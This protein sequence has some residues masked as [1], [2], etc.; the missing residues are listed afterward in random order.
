LCNFAIIFTDEIDTNR[1]FLDRDE[2]AS[3][4]NDGAIR[5]T[6][7]RRGGMMMQNARPT[8]SR[9]DTENVQLTLS[10]LALAAGLS[11]GASTHN[12]PAASGRPN[13]STASP[14]TPG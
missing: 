5:G 6:A 7:R 8:R 9:R 12:K 2:N 4:S 1:L 11:S 13:N 3:I 10:A 14:S